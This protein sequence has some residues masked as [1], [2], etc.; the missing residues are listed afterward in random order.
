[1][2][3]GAWALL[4]TRNSEFNWMTDLDAAEMKRFI[5][6]FNDTAPGGDTPL[7]ALTRA[8]RAHLHFVCIH[9]FEDGNGRIGRLLIA[10]LVAF[11][12]RGL[13]GPY[14][15]DANISIAFT[16]VAVVLAQIFVSAPFFIR[17][18]HLRPSSRGGMKSLPYTM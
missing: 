5:A 2:V 6:W 3:L 14:L 13:L 18:A 1:M 10:L 17:S 9:P 4:H 7:P 8:A 16:Q 15:Q 11:G 12:R